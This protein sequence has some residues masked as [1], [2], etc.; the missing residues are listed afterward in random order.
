MKRRH[1][2]PTPILRTKLK[3]QIST[4]FNEIKTIK[5]HLLNIVAKLAA[6]RCYKP[7]RISLVFI[8]HLKFFLIFNEYITNVL[9]DILLSYPKD[10]LTIN[11]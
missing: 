4:I 9:S 3:N 8:R 1:E 2:L 10:I 7:T 6:V 5:I 11:F